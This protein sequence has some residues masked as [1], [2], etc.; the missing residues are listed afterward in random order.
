M[1]TAHWTK[2]LPPPRGTT[3]APGA[4]A[5]AAGRTGAAASSGSGGGERGVGSESEGAT[6]LDVHLAVVRL[7]AY[8]TD[9]LISVCRPRRGPSGT[10]VQDAEVLLSTLRSLEIHN[11][12]LF[13][14]S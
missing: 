5:E 4:A 2:R 11:F 9:L 12:G 13:G 14:A 3:A 7:E 1:A 8:A 6:E 10:P